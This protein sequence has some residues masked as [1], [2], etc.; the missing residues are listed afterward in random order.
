MTQTARLL[1]QM[2]R[3]STGGMRLPAQREKVRGGGDECEREI[4]R[5]GEREL[6]N[7]VLAVY[8]ILGL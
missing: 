2:A 6:C 1:L 3:V 7:V 5:R 8:L 4:D